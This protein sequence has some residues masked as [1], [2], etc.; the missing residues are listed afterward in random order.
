VEVEPD[1]TKWV[2]KD[3]RLSKA[4]FEKAAKEVT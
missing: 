4:E 2:Y 3:S 1:L